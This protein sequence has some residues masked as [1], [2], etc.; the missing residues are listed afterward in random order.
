M[1]EHESNPAQENP[2]TQAQAEQPVLQP[3][4]PEAKKTKAKKPK[5]TRR[6]VST[7][8]I[9]VGVVL[10]LGFGIYEGMTYPWKTLLA[11]WGM[12]TIEDTPDALPEPAALPGSATLIPLDDQ[13]NMED[14][15][16]A[17]AELPDQPNFFA[18]RPAMNISRLGTIKIPKIQISENIV[19]GTVDELLYGV[20]HARGTALPGQPGNCVLAG[21]RN[22]VVMRPFRYLD[23]VE[24]GDN[25]YIT[26]DTST[27]TYEVFDIFEIT[28]DEIWVMQAQEDESH[29]LTLITCTPV[30]TYTNRMIVRARLVDD[31]SA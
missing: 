29:M 27:Y 31:I 25:I 7:I 17:E 1:S 6:K 10:I 19:E 12:A 26:D 21:H 4:P 2:E 22:Y 11:D 9:L 16:E 24:I 30:L 5:S 3:D 8:L 15:E 13:P 14:L 23:K 20:G 28:P 18:T